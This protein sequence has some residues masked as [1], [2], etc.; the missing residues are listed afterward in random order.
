MTTSRDRR[1]GFR[2]RAARVT[3]TAPVRSGGGGWCWLIATEATLFA[4]LIASYFYLRFR[5][6]TGVAA[7]RH[8]GSPRSSLPLIMS[9]ILLSPSI[10]V[11]IAESGDQEGKQGRLKAG[12]AARLRPRASSSWF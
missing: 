3:P 1:H 9:V 11:H 4:A 5:S 8:R 2:G 7:R 10:P 6:G 12:L